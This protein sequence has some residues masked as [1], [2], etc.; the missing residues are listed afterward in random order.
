L[1]AIVENNDRL[2]EC[3]AV[4]RQLVALQS[5]PLLLLPLL[6]VMMM[7]LINLVLLVMV[8]MVVVVMVVIKLVNPFEKSRALDY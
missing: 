7:L 6:A 2:K 5:P 1:D 8:D 4:V 3:S